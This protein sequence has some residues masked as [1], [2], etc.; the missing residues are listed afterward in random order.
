MPWSDSPEHELVGSKNDYKKRQ[1]VMRRV[2]WNTESAMER[3][4]DSQAYPKE[5]NRFPCNMK[6]VLEAA[7]N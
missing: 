6:F 5:A 4:F 1:I 7:D 2:R 3:K